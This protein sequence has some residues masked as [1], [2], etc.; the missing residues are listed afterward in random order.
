MI[1]DKIKQAE[2]TRSGFFSF[3]PYS[4]LLGCCKNSS[5]FGA[6]WHCIAKP[7]CYLLHTCKVSMFA[8]AEKDMCE[9]FLPFRK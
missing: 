4:I 9:A 5:R 3:D 1:L 2:I 7:K 8:N 6:R